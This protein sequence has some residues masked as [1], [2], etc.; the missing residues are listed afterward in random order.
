MLFGAVITGKIA[1]KYG[2]KNTLIY[3][4]V[5]NFIISLGFWK[6]NMVAIL[7]ILR[8]LMGF[9]YGFSMPLTVSSMTEIVPI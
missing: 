5:L 2:R 8:F 9:C 4:G 3:S 1:D 7:V 6:A